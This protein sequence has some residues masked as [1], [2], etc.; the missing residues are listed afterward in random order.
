[1]AKALQVRSKAIW[2][3]FQCYNSAASA[4]DPPR[5]HLLWEEVIDYTFLADFDIL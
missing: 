5:Q 4:L 3:A 1:I 2:S